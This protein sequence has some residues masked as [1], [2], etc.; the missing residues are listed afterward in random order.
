MEVSLSDVWQQARENHEMYSKTGSAEEDI[1]FFAL[2]LVGEAGEV[3]NFVKKRWR[4]G[5]SH[6]EDLKKEC[7]DVIAYTIMLADA[8]GMTQADL[9]NMV[10]YKQRVFVE[11]MEARDNGVNV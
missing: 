3:A 5:D 2:G 7:A 6:N 10:A 11:K 4:D 8:L 9:I 1:R